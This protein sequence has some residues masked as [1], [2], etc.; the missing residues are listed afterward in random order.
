MQL[1]PETQRAV[2]LAYAQC[3]RGGWRLP[4]VDNLSRCAM[5]ATSELMRLR[6]SSARPEPLAD[7]DLFAPPAPAHSKPILSGSSLRVVQLHFDGGCSGNPGNKYGSFEA[8]AE[9]QVLARGHRIPFGHGTN[10]EAEFD[11]L[12]AGLRATADALR[13]SERDLR[14]VRL[15]A[16]TDST[17]VRNR[18][19]RK[20]KVHSK[21]SWRESS[22]RMYD[23]ARR[24]LDV[25]EGF[26]A[27]TVEWVPRERNVE[28]FGH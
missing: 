26:G 20:N 14:Q 28:R 2:E 7:R 10:N 18:L 22:Q 6:Q 1:K 8:L 11:A 27:F 9:G 3:H 17:I 21:P 15:Q 16:F 13:A 23:L 25:L 19:T 5:R 12:Q 24:A 4:D